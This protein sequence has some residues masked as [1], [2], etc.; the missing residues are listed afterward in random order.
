MLESYCKGVMKMTQRARP[1]PGQSSSIGRWSVVVGCGALLSLAGYTQVM[2]R[3]VRLASPLVPVV[4]DT[5]AD[6]LVTDAV[7]VHQTAVY[8]FQTAFGYFV[9]DGALLT[10][11]LRYPLN[12][13]SVSD[14]AKVELNWQATPPGWWNYTSKDIS[15]RINVKDARPLP[16]RADPS[17]TTPDDDGDNH[18]PDGFVE[19]IREAELD[20]GYLR[21][22]GARAYL[23]TA[24]K[25]FAVTPPGADPAVV[26]VY[27]AELY[28]QEGYADIL[29]ADLF[30]SGVPLNT[31][32]GVPLVRLGRHLPIR[33]IAHGDVEKD[34][35]LQTLGLRNFAY[36]KALDNKQVV[37]HGSST[38]T[39]VYRAAIAKF[40]TALSLAGDSSRIL[41]LA[42]VGKGRALLDLGLYAAA[43]AAVAKV[44]QG[45]VYNMHPW[46]NLDPDGDEE[47]GTVADRE[48]GNGLPYL[49]SGDPRTATKDIR[50]DKLV[51]YVKVP[52]KWSEL[53]GEGMGKVMLSLAS[54]EE[55][56]LIKAEAALHKHAADPTWLRLLN[57]LR[58]TA[59]IPGTTQPDP[60]KL[61]PLKDPG[62][63]HGRIALLFAERAY[64][65]FVTGQRQGDMRRLV[66]Q[67][68]WPQDQ[69]YPT[70]SYVVP[71]GFI[72]Q[73]GKYGTDVNMPIPPMERANPNFH[74]CLDRG[75]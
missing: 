52:A 5:A 7:E 60:A 23:S 46:M 51:K 62:T 22:Q 64:W 53:D 1:T 43:A 20:E 8:A 40:D 10:D 71:E 49:S 61:T 14:L 73:V 3:P 18:F 48:G 16:Q 58:A 54:G 63:E 42:R 50:G 24:I 21:M 69:V 55:A 28:A 2:G 33:K 29:L 26:K 12:G 74:G 68:H 30:C 39:Q 56:V 15:R 45:F 11:E 36:K 9:W 41:N 72:G 35:Y 44:P 34:Y 32:A 65:L 6:T 25:Q 38:T 37:Y 17:D 31:F 70:G 27:R 57:Q 59:P 19:H 67:Y 47:I 75:A 13:M 66:R 4:S